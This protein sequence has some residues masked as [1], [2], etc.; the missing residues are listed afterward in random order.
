MRGPEKPCADSSSNSTVILPFG[1]PRAR[2]GPALD[3]AALEGWIARALAEAAARGVTGKDVTPFLLARLAEAS[4]GRTL[5][6]N[7]ALLEHNA[8][9][10]GQIAAAYAATYAKVM[11]G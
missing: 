3:P 7:I 10:A 11:A 5:A 9:L 4:G 1:E 6:A 8:R 2:F